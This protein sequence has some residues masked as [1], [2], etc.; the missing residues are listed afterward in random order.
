MRSKLGLQAKLDL[1]GLSRSCE[2][3]AGWS[4]DVQAL[5]KGAFRPFEGAPEFEVIAL[6]GHSED[7]VGLLLPVEQSLF[8]GD[9]LFRHGPTVVFHRWG[10]C[11][12]I[13]QP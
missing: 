9:V 5:P 12:F 7:S 2:E 4:A 6:P 8:T 1:G 11:Q 13:L 3:K 10:A